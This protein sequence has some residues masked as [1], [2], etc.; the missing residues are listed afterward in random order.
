MA[1]RSEI[2]PDMKHCPLY[3]MHSAPCTKVSSPSSGTAARMARISFSVFSRAS[4]TRSMPS[5][6]ALAAAHRQAPLALGDGQVGEAQRCQRRELGGLE[7]DVE[8][9]VDASPPLMGQATGLAHLV[10]GELRSLVAGVEALGAQVHGVG[11]VGE[12]GAHGVERAGGS[13]Q[14]GDGEA[15]HKW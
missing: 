4:T 11:P 15:R 6:V 8:G 2:I 3:E 13:E 14:L 7:E 10:Q 9:E 5:L 1:L 12:R